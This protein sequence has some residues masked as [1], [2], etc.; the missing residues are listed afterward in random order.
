MLSK[1]QNCI[2]NKAECWNLILLPMMHCTLYETFRAD[3]N[4]ST[5]SQPLFLI[6]N[7]HLNSKNVNYNIGEHRW[8]NL[9]KLPIWCFADR[10]KHRPDLM[11]DTIIG[12]PLEP[13]NITGY[14]VVQ[15]STLPNTCTVQGPSKMRECSHNSLLKLNEGRWR[16]TVEAELCLPDLYA[17]RWT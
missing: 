3:M 13:I 5:D 16:R 4:V 14:T 1:Q 2:D 8:I 7:K 11:A 10:A 12:Q 15:Y 6:Q 9:L 17:W